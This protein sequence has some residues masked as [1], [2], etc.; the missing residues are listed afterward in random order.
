MEMGTWFY[1]SHFYPIVDET[2][3]KGL[4]TGLR[5]DGRVSN[6]T[7]FNRALG[8]AGLHISFEM[9]EVDVLVLREPEY[10]IT[11]GD[12]VKERHR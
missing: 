8:K 12:T 2:G 6:L 9:R 4:I 5:E 7:E 1:R 10:P 11:T 3:Y